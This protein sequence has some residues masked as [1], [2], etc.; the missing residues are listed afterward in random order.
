[1]LTTWTPA[2]MTGKR[3]KSKSVCR[4]QEVSSMISDENQGT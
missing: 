2:H 1:M 4:Q 3:G